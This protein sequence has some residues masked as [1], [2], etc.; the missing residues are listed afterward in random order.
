MS[1]LSDPK[2]W[3]LLEQR[4]DAVLSVKLPFDE[5][6]QSKLPINSFL[7]LGANDLAAAVKDSFSKYCGKDVKSSIGELVLESGAES[8]DSISDEIKSSDD[9]SLNL[10]TPTSQQS[11]RPVTTRTS[12]VDLIIVLLPQVVRLKGRYCIWYYSTFI[13]EIPAGFYCCISPLDLLPCKYM[14]L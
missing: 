2:V 14:Q 13:A 7:V 5:F 8:Q 12:S 3:Q 11:T 9:A 1:T 6:A 10:S 4:C